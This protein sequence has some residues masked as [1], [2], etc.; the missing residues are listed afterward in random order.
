MPKFHPTGCSFFLAIVL[1]AGI[2]GSACADGNVTP[3]EIYIAVATGGPTLAAPAS[4]RP[5]STGAS[6]ATSTA[7]T[8]SPTAQPNASAT[9]A[10]PS[11]VAAATSVSQPTVTPKAS[12]VSLT[13]RAANL[14]FDKTAVRV[15]VGATIAATMQ[16]DDA[17]QEHN[18]TFG[19]PGLP[20]GNTCK[21]PCASTQV[22]KVDAPGAYSF[23]CTIHD[24]FGTFTVDP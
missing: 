2:A 20:H 12:A 24:M 5:P 10:V 17:G 15:P 19:L 3:A 6:S 4:S 23:L 8:T 9:A 22:F 1:A 7:A 16:N 18:L 21:G 11:L 14:A 13:F